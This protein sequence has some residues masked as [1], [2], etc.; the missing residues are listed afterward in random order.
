MDLISKWGWEKPTPYIKK[1]EEHAFYMKNTL[2]GEILVNEG[3]ISKEACDQLIKEK[4]QKT[5]TLDWFSSNVPEIKPWI[6]QILSF[7]NDYPYYDKLD[8]FTIHPAMK[9]FEVL[10][11]A[12]DLDCLLLLIEESKPLIVFSSFSGIIKY[13]SLGR[14]EIMLDPIHKILGIQPYLALAKREDILARLNAL[15]SNTPLHLA[16]GKE[17]IWDSTI[18]NTIEQKTCARIIDFALENRA[19]DIAIDPTRSGR[20]EV[21]VRRDGSLI[22]CSLRE[23]MYEFCESVIFF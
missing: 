4:P 20:Y 16:Q 9:D 2:S 14:E 6:D 5:Q 11:R 1:L 19:T 15:K 22:P 17:I 23:K 21:K 10:S 13:E 12:D 18:S 3:V 7:K 8:I